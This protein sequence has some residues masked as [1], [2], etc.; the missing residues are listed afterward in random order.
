MKND[1]G[2]TVVGRTVVETSS[3]DGETSSSDSDNGSGSDDD[4]PVVNLKKECSFCSRGKKKC[5][6][7]SGLL[8]VCDQEGC[9]LMSTHLCAIAHY[10]SCHPGEDAPGGG[11]LVRCIKHCRYYLSCFCVLFMC[12]CF[13]ST[14]LF[15]VGCARST[16]TVST[17]QWMMRRRERRW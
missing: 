6:F 11:K 10:S 16:V 2:L 4:T 9:G 8:K 5:E 17:W 15:Y 3:C 12:M 7:P 13:L 14:A 1:G